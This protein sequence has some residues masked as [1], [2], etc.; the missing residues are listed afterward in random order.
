MIIRDRPDG[1]RIKVPSFQGM[2]PYLFRTRTESTIYFKQQVC[3]S[4][5]LE[6]IEERNKDLPKGT[7]NVTFFQICLC[8]ALYTV[9]QRPQLN[10]FTSGHHFYQ[11]NEIVFSFVAKKQLDDGG[12]EINVKIPFYPDDTIFSVSEKINSYI[13]R[14]KKEDKNTNTADPGF[15]MKFPRPILKLIMGTFRLLDYFNMA[16]GSMLK[17]DPFY[18]TMFITNVGSVG[19]DSPYHHLF[20][21]GNNS[22]FAAIGKIKKGPLVDEQ[23]GE[24]KVVDLV[25]ITFT[26]DDRI[27]DGIYSARSIDIL[28]NFIENPRL[29]ENPVGLSVEQIEKLKLKMRSV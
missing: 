6:Y 25:D 3:L 8:A 9:L 14:H 11:R 1:I 4:R 7:K 12:E 5:T 2:L 16:P 27:A 21:W 15:F 23:T 26:L 17:A 20:E 19:I 24:I 28:K 13:H 18:S 10:I 29:M 22:V